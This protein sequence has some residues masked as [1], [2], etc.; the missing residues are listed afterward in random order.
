M[1]DPSDATKPRGSQTLDRGLQ[2]L[3]LLRDNPDGLSVAEMVRVL[4]LPRTVLTRLVTTLE[5]ES[6]VER[7]EARAYR[8]GPALI[9]LGQAVRTDLAAVAGTILRDLAEQVGASVVLV[10]RHGDFGVVISVTEPTNRRLRLLFRLGS[11]HPLQ[12]GAEG[13]AILAGNP[14]RPGE[15]L[16]VTEARR[17]GYAVS[18]GEILE[19]TWG[20]AAPVCGLSGRCDMS[21]GVIAAAAAVDLASTADLVIATAQRLAE[22]VGTASGIR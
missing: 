6:Y 4:H 1:T 8:L 14:A 2:V 20:L 17:L 11:R 21:V 7:T 5:D 15:R 18:S 9:A 10:V 16:E 22:R 12:Q 3:G 19:G 13:R